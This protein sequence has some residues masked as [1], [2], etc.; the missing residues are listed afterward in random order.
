MIES[1]TFLAIETRAQWCQYEGPWRNE[2]DRMSGHDD[3]TGLPWI[4]LRHSAS[5]H[6]CGYVGVPPG[7]P[8]HGRD[9]DSVYAEVHGGLT[10]AGP[11]QPEEK[12][13]HRVCHT[14]QPGESDDVWWLGFDCAHL[15][16]LAPARSS[17]RSRVGR[18]EWEQ[19]RDVPY[20]RAECTQLAAQAAAAKE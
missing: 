15:G 16:D 9:Y 5:G 12:G 1:E 2:P 8:W 11:C 4:L 10:F 6:W 7:H 3:D 14:P 17:G 13:E 20:V 18:A 19:Y